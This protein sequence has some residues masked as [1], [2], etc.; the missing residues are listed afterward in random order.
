M[1]TQ[2]VLTGIGGQGVLFATRLLAETALRSGLSIMG[3]ETHGMSQRGGSVTSHLKIGG[4]AS[5]MVGAGCADLLVAFQVDEGY[6]N[7][8]FLRPA[9]GDGGAGGRLVIN[10]PGARLD[11]RARAA[12]DRAGVRFSALDA[13]VV[14]ERIGA[15]LVTNLITLG[16]ASKSDDFPFDLDAI[17]DTVKAISPPR[18]LDL[19]VQALAAGS[20][21]TQ[22]GG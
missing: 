11:E 12:L 14:A 4:Y 22:E 17:T 5:C 15:P 7:L 16:F 8:S 2:V 3:S 20:E 19:N 10:A 1:T 13:A 9:S 6:R 18:F 21:I